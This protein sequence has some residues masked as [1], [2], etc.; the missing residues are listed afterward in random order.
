[1]VACQV[2]ACPRPRPASWRRCLPTVGRHGFRTCCLAQSASAR[3]HQHLGSIWQRVPRLFRKEKTAVHRARR[4]QATR[5][6]DGACG[7][8]FGCVAC[9]PLPDICLRPDALRLPNSRL[10]RGTEPNSQRPSQAVAFKQRP[11]GSSMTAGV[12]RRRPTPQRIH[13]MCPQ[14]LFM[15]N[16]S[17]G[18]EPANGRGSSSRRRP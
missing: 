6:Q 13:S 12:S 3:H 8:P 5:P 11:P 9:P 16:G 7:R 2:A 4:G 10:K 1:M 18:P 15:S 17:W 14:V